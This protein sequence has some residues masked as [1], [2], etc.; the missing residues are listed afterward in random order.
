MNIPKRRLAAVLLLISVFCVTLA[1]VSCKSKQQKTANQQPATQQP[2]GTAQGAS[3]TVED[4]VA[5][6]ALYP[7]M[8]LTQILTASTNSQE[9]LDAG[10]WLLQNQN[11]KG[12]QLGAAAKQAGFGPSVQYLVHFPQVVDNMCRQMDW[13]KQLGA[14]FSQNQKAVM[15]AIQKLRGEAQQVGNLQSTPQ[16]SV[17]T[18]SEGDAKYIEIEP[19]DPKVV[20]V[21]QYNPT[22]VYTTPPPAQ[23]TTSSTTSESSGVSKETAVATSLLSFGVGMALGAAINNNDYYYPAPAWGYGGVYYGGRPYYPAAIPYRPAYTAAWRPATGYYPPANYRWNSA[24]GNRVYVNNNYYNRFHTN[25]NYQNRTAV[26]NRQNW[27]GQSTYAGARPSNQQANSPARRAY[28]GT[29]PRVQSGTR[30]LNT[31]NYAAN[32]NATSQNYAANR[33]AISQNRAVP[34]SSAAAPTRPS[35]ASTG[36]RGY[37]TEARNSTPPNPASRES[38]ST[39]AAQS[40]STSSGGAFSANASGRSERSASNRGRASLGANSGSGRAGRRR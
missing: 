10:N 6:I 3:F 34:Q 8:L 4:L 15:D 2:P 27:R 13:T 36:D 7:D 14:A 35:R 20:Y 40:R 29:T 38:G 28:T 5:P 1:V 17:E 23:T 24:N 37:A 26:Q 16:Q 33:N 9:V 39:S 30:N 22:V 25:S 11:L 19:A 31:S 12:T 32:R 21:P 18:K